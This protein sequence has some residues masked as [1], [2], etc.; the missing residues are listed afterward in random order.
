MKVARDSFVWQMIWIALFSLHQS[1]VDVYSAPR[2][3]PPPTYPSGAL[4]DPLASLVKKTNTAP[5]NGGSP[6]V[7]PDS[8]QVVRVL[9]SKQVPK[10]LFPDGKEKIVLGVFHKAFF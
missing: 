7:L 9:N 6:V 1:S 8:A 10:E 5:T 3:P 4:R 2:P